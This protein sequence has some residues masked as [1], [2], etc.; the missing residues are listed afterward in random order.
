M[1]TEGATIVMVDPGEETDASATIEAA[2]PVNGIV[3]A[4]IMIGWPLAVVGRHSV[5]DSPEKT[6]TGRIRRRASAVR[7]AAGISASSSRIHH[8]QKLASPSRRACSFTRAPKA[9]NTH[10]RSAIGGLL[11]E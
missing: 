7:G 1:A 9:G 4:T 3:V 10:S 5:A 2:S 8:C 6:S 11:F